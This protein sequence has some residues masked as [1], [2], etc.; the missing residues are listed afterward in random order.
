[1]THTISRRSFVTTV[2]CAGAAAGIN[3]TLPSAA[4]NASNTPNPDPNHVLPRGKGFKVLPTGDD[5]RA[6]LEWALCN[7]QSGGTVKLEKGTYK[8]GGTAI[9]PDFDGR[10][11]GEGR[12][13]T[14]ITCTDEYNYEIWE[15]NGKVDPRPLPFPRRNIDGSSTKAPPGLILFYKT[16]INGRDP[17]SLANRIEIKGVRCRGAMIGSEWTFGDEVLCFSVVNSVDWNNVNVPQEPTR[18]DFLLADVLVDGYRSEEFG[19]YQNGCACITIT[20]APILTDNYDLRGATDGDAF[21][22]EN[23]ALLGT[24]PAPGDVTFRDCT[25]VNCRLGPGVVGH[26]DSRIVFDNIKTQNCRGNC[27]QIIDNSNCDVVVRECDL[28]NDTFI[29]PPELTPGGTQTDIPSSL[30]CIAIFSGFSNGAG[31]PSN[32]RFL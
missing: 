30:G 18:Q 28:F 10:L 19:V 13:K 26:K 32:L 31:I 8:M 7:T 15:G 11:V 12:R 21:G 4:A 29:L 16:P 22:A 24:V 2:G 5:D 25:F 27:L 3:L 14:T 1:M 23:G 9:V 6:N 20:G 17:E